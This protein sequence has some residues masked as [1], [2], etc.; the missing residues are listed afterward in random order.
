MDHTIQFTVTEN[1]SKQ[2]IRT[3]FG[4][5]RDLMSLL[6]DK[7]Y[8]DGFGEC[9]GTGRCATCVIRITGIVENALVKDRNEPATLLKMG[10]EDDDIRL[11]CQI[12]VTEDLN[13][14]KIEILG[15]Y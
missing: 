7:L 5:Y 3:Y 10:F 13:N 2:V 14:A 9:G 12:L 6:K 8:I 1:N 15:T 11:S 4:E